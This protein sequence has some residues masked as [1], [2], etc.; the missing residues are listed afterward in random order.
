METSEQKEVHPIDAVPDS[1]LFRELVAF[2]G[3]QRVVELVGWAMIAGLVSEFVADGNPAELRRKME[4]RGFTYSSLYRALRDLRRF[5]E[6]IEGRSYPAQDHRPT[7][8]VME[9]VSR[10]SAA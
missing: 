4:E 9:R 1:D 2:F 7:L 6:H 8:R 10:L 5:G 3:P